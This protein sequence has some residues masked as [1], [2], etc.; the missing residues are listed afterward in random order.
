MITEF[1]DM[2]MQIITGLVAMPLVPVAFIYR[3]LLEA[4]KRAI[5]T[6]GMFLK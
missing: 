2:I 1:L 3:V 6:S 4:W 5:R